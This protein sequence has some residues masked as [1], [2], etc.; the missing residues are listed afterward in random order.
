MST[1]AALIG[2]VVLLAYA[3]GRLLSWAVDGAP[4]IALALAGAVELALGAGCLWVLMRPVAHGSS[5]SLKRAADHDLT[6][7]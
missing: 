5:A 6:E 1:V 4:S 7:A 2:A 3:G